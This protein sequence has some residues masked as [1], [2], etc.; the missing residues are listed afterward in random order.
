MLTGV[1]YGRFAKKLGADPG[2]DFTAEARSFFAA[3]TQLQELYISPELLAPKDWD[4][5]AAGAK[6]SRENAAV[7]ADSHWIGGNPAALEIYGWASWRP[8]KGVFALR[9][10]AAEAGEFDVELGRILELPPGAPVAFVMKNPYPQ[11]RIAALAG[12]VDARC[13]VRIRL[14]PFEVLVFEALPADN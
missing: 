14:D 2:D 13:P 11:R 1:I 5:I 7:L 12:R 8:G 6:W 3:G 4:A 10:P 9:N